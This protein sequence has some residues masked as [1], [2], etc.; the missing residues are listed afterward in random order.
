MVAG[1]PIGKDKQLSKSSPTFLKTGS[2][3]GMCPFTGSGAAQPDHF[4]NTGKGTGKWAAGGPSG[5]MIGRPGRQQ[6]PGK[7]T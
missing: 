5:Q 7:T 2:S 6:T 3:N 4:V 1:G